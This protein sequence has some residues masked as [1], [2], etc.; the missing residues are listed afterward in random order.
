MVDVSAESEGRHPRVRLTPKYSTRMISTSHFRAPK[1]FVTTPS[2]G[3]VGGVPCLSQ[4]TDV[5]RKHSRFTVGG[6]ETGKAPGSLI[7]LF[8]PTSDSTREVSFER[9]HVFRCCRLGYR[10]LRRCEKPRKMLYGLGLKFTG[11]PIR[12]PSDFHLPARFNSHP[13]RLRIQRW[14]PA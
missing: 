13:R 11:L 3:V 9:F 8:V 7:L 2:R 12:L 6:G 4:T 5:A 10:V 14:I 1:R